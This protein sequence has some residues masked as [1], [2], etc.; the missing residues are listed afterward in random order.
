M[1]TSASRSSWSP[2]RKS[3]RSSSSATAAAQ[4]ATTG[5]IDPPLSPRNAS[6]TLTA[7]LDPASRT[8]TGSEVITWRNI[9]A[10]PAT[11]LQFHLYWNA[12]KNRR[13]TFMRESA[14]GGGG[15]DSTRLPNEW[16][17]IDVSSVSVAGVDRTASR[18]YIAP[19]DDNAED[20]TVM[21]VPL[22]NPIAPGA[23]AEIRAAWSAHVPRTFARTGAVG[24]FFFIANAS[25]SSFSAS[26]NCPLS[27]I[28]KA[29]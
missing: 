5:T 18:R 25:R 3:R 13:S 15:D 24:S 2:S 10:R 11:E 20:E 12:W 6:Y 22:A 7:R 14:L 9:T 28:N 4:P 19:D 23:T 26:L 8:I 1:L 17:R 21:V 29:R 27:F 16:A